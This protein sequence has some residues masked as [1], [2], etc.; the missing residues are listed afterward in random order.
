MINL[1]GKLAKFHKEIINRLFK[2][3]P[4]ALNYSLD[5]PL[6]IKYPYSEF[7][8]SVF[9]LIRTEYGPEKLRIRTLLTYPQV[10][11]TRKRVLVFLIVFNSLH[12]TNIFVY[13]LK[14]IRKLLVF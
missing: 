6:H 10:L 4:L 1:K 9:S 5:I 3:N 14:N 11:V 12:T 7:I 8:W 13:P 2:V